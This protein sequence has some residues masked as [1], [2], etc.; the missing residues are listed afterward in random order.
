MRKAQTPKQG[1]EPGIGADG[2]GQRFSS[3]EN[4]VVGPLRKGC[5][6][7]LKRLLLLAQSRVNRGEKKRW[8]I[9]FRS[10]IFKLVNS[11]QSLGLPAGGGICVGERHHHRRILRTEMPI[12][13][14][15]CHRVSFLARARKITSCTFIAAPRRAVGAHRDAPSLGG[16]RISPTAS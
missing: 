14:A 8:D 6:E 3:E 13:F 1:V 16:S 11:P 10:Q 4:E 15:A 2:V 9:S 5:L 7:I 12:I